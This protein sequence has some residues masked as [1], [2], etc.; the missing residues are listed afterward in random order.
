MEIKSCVEHLK[1]RLALELM[2][3]H[4]NF[5]FSKTDTL[6]YTFLSFCQPLLQAAMHELFAINMLVTNVISAKQNEKK[7]GGGDK[8]VDTAP[9]PVFGVALQG[10]DVKKQIQRIQ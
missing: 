7:K 9:H 4:C 6:F 2:D 3:S 5:Q 10:G 1:I 8:D